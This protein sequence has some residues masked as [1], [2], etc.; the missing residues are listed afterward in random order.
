[1]IQLTLGQIAEI[2]GGELAGGA[3]ADTLSPEL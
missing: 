1:M 3:Q 2:T